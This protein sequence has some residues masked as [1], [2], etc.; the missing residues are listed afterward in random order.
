MPQ[1]PKQKITTSGKTEDWYEK[2]GEAIISNASFGNL[3]LNDVQKSYDLYNGAID[4][5][6]YNYVTNPYNSPQMNKR[7]FPA[8]LRNYNII[9]PVID[10]LIGEKSKRPFN[11]VTFSTSPEVF[12]EKEKAIMDEVAKDM[13]QAFINEANK[14]GMD[15]GVPSKKVGDTK[16]KVEKLQSTFKDEWSKKGSML[17]EY[18]M[19]KLDIKEEFLEMFFHWLVSGYAISY[20]DR[21][22]DE[23]IYEAVNPLDIAYHKSRDTRFIQDSKWAVRR[24]FMTSTEVVDKFSDELTDD[25]IDE[26][27]NPSQLNTAMPFTYSATGSSTGSGYNSPEGREEV[28]V[29][30]ITWQGY[31]KKGILTYRDKFGMEQEEEVSEHY[32]PLGDEEVDWYW[33]ICTH[34]LYRIDGRFYKLGGEI[35]HLEGKLPY[36]GRVYSDINSVPTS[37]ALIGL[38]YQILYNINH[39]RLEWTMAKNKDKIMLMEINSIPKRHGW[40]EDKFM[41]FADAM[42]FAF[43][44][45]T[46]EGNM[47]Q[48]VNF[49]QYQV[50]DMSLSQYIASQFELLAVIKQE[51]EDQIGINRQRKGQTLASDGVGSNERAVFQ[52]SMMTEEINRRFEKLEEKDLQGL[53][54]LSSKYCYL[55]GLVSNYINPEGRTSMIE[56]LPEELTNAD[57]GIF[58]KNSSKENEKIENLKSAA[59]QFAQNGTSFSSIADILDTEDFASIKEKIREVEKAEKEYQKELEKTKGE[60]QE[61]VK[62]IE[63]KAK[64]REHE[65]KIELEDMKG[66]NSMKEVQLKDKTDRYKIDSE[67]NIKLEE[68]EVKREENEIK[69]E[70]LK[71]SKQ[72]LEL[73]EKYRPKEIA[74]KQSK[75]TA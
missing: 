54:D 13:Q 5:K 60:S 50:M 44:D 37:L 1:L 58:I 65:R 24:N 56:L 9:K 36:N 62:K 48:K 61:R 73:D 32:K 66:E 11:Y 38:P 28:E 39:F 4:P 64:D 57:L 25:E 40:D 2:T 12:T 63:M 23:P 43:V 69:R 30:H 59:V 41:Y 51:W 18:V 3:H 42:G 22:N 71:I 26:I 15:T 46:A 74:A 33:D 52:S 68:I 19:Q 8:K 45:S 75:K 47:K 34:E 31:K 20:K 67:E 17:M 6:D 10:L 16:K 70:E 35:S 7:K 72:Q 21:E 29:M 27:E 55:D 49:N 53:L 14:M